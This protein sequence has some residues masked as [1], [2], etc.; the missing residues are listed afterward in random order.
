MTPLILSLDTGW[1]LV[2]KFSTR[3][4]Y[5]QGGTA[6]Y[7]KYL[8]HGPQIGYGLFGNDKKNTFLV[9]TQLLKPG[10]RQSTKLAV[11]GSKARLL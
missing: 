9:K 10:L 7:N 11:T 3:Q 6:V 4:L 2:G 8:V 1:R 5:P